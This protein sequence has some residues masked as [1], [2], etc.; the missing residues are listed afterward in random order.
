MSEPCYEI[1]PLT[2]AKTSFCLQVRLNYLFEEQQHVKFEV[3]DVDS[4]SGNLA[5]HDFIGQ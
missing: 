3:Y 5:D 4:R 1:G 2:V